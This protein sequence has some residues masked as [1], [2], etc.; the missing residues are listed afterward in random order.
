M[1]Y[2]TLAPASGYF[3]SLG[4]RKPHLHAI[5]TIPAKGISP[6][7]DRDAEFLARSSEGGDTH[8]RTVGCPA[9]ASPIGRHLP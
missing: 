6:V 5:F 8:E 4:Q 3:T 7:N 2:V 9:Y 1:S